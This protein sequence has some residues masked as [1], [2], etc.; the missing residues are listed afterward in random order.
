MELI[1]PSDSNL[2]IKTERLTLEPV[3]ISHA[4]EMAILLKDPELYDFVPQD[5]PEVSNLRKTYEV[6]SKR[7][8]PSRDELWFN[9]VARLN[10]TNKA[11]G[12]FQAGVKSN[13][14]SNV[15]YTVGL[16][17]QRQGFA[18]EALKSILAFLNSTMGVKTVKAW[19]DTRNKASIDLVKKIGMVQVDFIKNA[20]H[21]KNADSDEYV[22]QISFD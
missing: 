6:W 22:Y 3:L 13:S 10:A 4:K 16:R 5:P 20:D 14:E 17:Y 15:A 8:S 12:H 21:F 1:A 18:T 9:W 2:L 19:I 11:V 7:I